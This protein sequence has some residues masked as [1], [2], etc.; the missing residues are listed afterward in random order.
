MANFSQF[1]ITPNQ[2]PDPYKTP[3]HT[4][5]LLIIGSGRCIWDDL[6]KVDYSIDW[7][8]MCVND[9][10]MHYPGDIHHAYSND[11]KTLPKWVA[12]RRPRYAIEYR[13]PIM[14]SCNKLEQGFTWPFPGH[15]TSGLGAIYVGLALG[16]TDIV[17]CG[18]PM[19]GSGHYFDP[20][21]RST[22]YNSGLRYWRAA[23]P[24]FNGAVHSMS[25]NTR[26][27]LGAPNFGKTN[28]SNNLSAFG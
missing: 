24:V 1:G 16:Y 13:T 17:L 8:V 6:A 19:D 15:G 2:F 5:S 18:I 3:Q 23:I 11:N 22:N 12:A 21:T 14:H 27:L 25:G 10:I 7:E 20:K 28:N 26:D 9:I 4:G